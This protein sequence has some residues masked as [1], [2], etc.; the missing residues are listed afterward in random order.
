MTTVFTWVGFITLLALMA[1]ALF[2][3]VSEFAHWFDQHWRQKAY[4]KD[5]FGWIQSIR[6]RIG[7]R[8]LDS[9]LGIRKYALKQ[10]YNACPPED[11]DRRERLLGMIYENQNTIDLRGA[12]TTYAGYYRVRDIK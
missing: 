12:D 1:M 11:D 7:I 8:F 2:V 4:D 9:Y 10:A 5:T 6:Y 3:A